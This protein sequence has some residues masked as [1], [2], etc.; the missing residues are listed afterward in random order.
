V[1]GSVE[2]AAAAAA[3]VAAPPA[4]AR[5]AG[6][7]NTITP[8]PAVLAQAAGVASSVGLGLPI[9]QVLPLEAVQ[10]SDQQDPLLV[11]LVHLLVQQQQ[12]TQLLLQQTQTLLQ[13]LVQKNPQLQELVSELQ[14][15]QQQGTCKA[16][17]AKE[18]CAGNVAA[19]RQLQEDGKQRRRSC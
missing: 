11:A 15:G 2:P 13:I 7:A 1:A 8:A 3:A 18:V 9:S 19:Y 4:L 17:G 12:H 14:A 5:A 6:V 10:V 16:A